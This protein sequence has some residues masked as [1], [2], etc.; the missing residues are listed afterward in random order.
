MKPANNAQKAK[1]HIAKAELK[2]SREE[3]EAFM[4]PYGVSSSKDLSFHQAQ[5]LLETFKN[6]GWKPKPKKRPAQHSSSRDQGWGAHKYEY[7][8]PR[9][10][11]MADPIQLRLAEVLWRIVARNPSDE[12]LLGFVHR[13][14]KV[15]NLT[16]LTKKQICA[17]LCGLQD[18]YE[19]CSTEQIT[20]RQSLLKP[21][22]RE[23]ITT[24][25]N[26]IIYMR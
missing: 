14:T 21:W 22:Q 9:P 16:W 5:E 1:L 12:A 20:D 7:L 4:A 8:R 26:Q 18:M 19:K 17:V 24:N 2:L 13:Q 15:K 3:Y 6:H 10:E 25:L 23:M 11:E